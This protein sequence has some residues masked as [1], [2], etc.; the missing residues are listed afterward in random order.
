[1]KNLKKV[2]MMNLFERIGYFAVVCL[3][4]V[5]IFLFYTNSSNRDNQHIDL[6]KNI[7]DSTNINIGKAIYLLKQAR[8]FKQKDAMIEA[9]DLYYKAA[10]LHPEYMDASSK[11]FLGDEL[12]E[13][14][15]IS[16]VKLN[17]KLQTNKQDKEIIA[18]LKIVY[19]MERRFGQGCE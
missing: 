1:M 10:K 19:K 12:K 4:F 8:E 2:M 9:I 14:I 17:Q 18:K 5:I 16:I 7:I 11:D 13:A 6:N 15:K 3:I